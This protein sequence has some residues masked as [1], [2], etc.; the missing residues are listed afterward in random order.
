MKDLIEEIQKV[1]DKNN[2][3]VHTIHL[4]LTDP[5]ILDVADN[6]GAFQ[7]TGS[8]YTE[9]AQQHIDSVQAAVNKKL[10]RLQDQK[11]LLERQV[12]EIEDAIEAL[13]AEE[14]Y[15]ET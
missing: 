1:S 14:P 9:V 2:R 15:P 13:E 7:Y 11:A 5:V 12:Q 6:V 10:E 8:S 3:T 4:Q